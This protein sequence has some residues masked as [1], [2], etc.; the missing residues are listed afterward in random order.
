MSEVPVNTGV[1]CGSAIRYRP[2]KPT[3]E[4]HKEGSTVVP[5]AN[6]LIKLTGD[7]RMEGATLVRTADLAIK[8]MSDC[9]MECATLVQTADSGNQT[10][11]RL[12]LG[13]AQPVSEICHDAESN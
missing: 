7:C 2:I 1:D 11:E 10:N 5:P 6:W 12:S 9:R 4:H 13:R 3:G 8:P